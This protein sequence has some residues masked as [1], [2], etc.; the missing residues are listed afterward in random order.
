MSILSYSDLYN[1]QGKART[2]ELFIEY[3]ENSV[4]SLSKEGKEGAVSLYKLFVNHAVDDPSEVQFALEVF[5]DVG[6]WLEL[7]KSP[8]LSDKL[9]DWRKVTAQIR[10]QKAF[11]AIIKEVEENGRSA[12]TAAKYLIEEPWLEV[13]SAKQK[14]VIKQDIA[15]SAE[16]AY[17]DDSI[18]KDVERLRSEG[19]LN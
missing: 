3:K 19:L 9:R 14:K 11:A 16:K 2:K 12:F 8:V 5:G 6:F 15:E 13:G 1:T 4:L 18:N 17:R 10:K 7:Q